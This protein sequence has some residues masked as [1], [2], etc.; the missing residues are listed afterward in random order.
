MLRPSGTAVATAARSSGG[1]MAASA[2]VAFGGRKNAGFCSNTC[3]HVMRC[4]RKENKLA[5]HADYPFADYRFADYPFADLTICF[6]IVLDLREN[7][8]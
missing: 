1:S 7:N 6:L 8:S 3:N 2:L 5:M 4:G